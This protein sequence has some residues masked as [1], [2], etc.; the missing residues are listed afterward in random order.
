MA[1]SIATA[2]V[3]AEQ[4]LTATGETDDVLQPP[5]GRPELHNPWG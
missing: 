5:T 1:P 2:V 3:Q 4:S